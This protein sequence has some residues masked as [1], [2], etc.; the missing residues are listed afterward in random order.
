MKNDNLS[1]FAA[2]LA[3]AIE[4]LGLNLSYSRELLF[5]RETSRQLDADAAAGTILQQLSELQ[6]E[7]RVRQM[8]GLLTSEE[9]S[10]LRRL[11]DQAQQNETIIRHLQ[12][13]QQAVETIREVN[14]EISSWLGVDFGTLARR[15]GRC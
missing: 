12:A 9:I 11:Q 14:Q 6:A 15:P 10:R 5:Y 13:Q 8:Q 1:P 7:L 3:E 2:R 4:S